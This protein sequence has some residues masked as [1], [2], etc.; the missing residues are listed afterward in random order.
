LRERLPRPKRRGK[1]LAQLARIALL[2]L[3]DFLLTP[4]SVV[5]AKDLLELIDDRSQVRSTPVVSQLPVENRHAGLPASDP[6]LADAILDD[7]GIDCRRIDLAIV[8]LAL[9]RLTWADTTLER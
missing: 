2:F 1:G 3:D 5:G 6:T 4:P 8:D 9:L 7:P